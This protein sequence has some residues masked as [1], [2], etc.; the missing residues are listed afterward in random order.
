M[1]KLVTLEKVGYVFKKWFTLEKLVRFN[2]IDHIW[3]NVCSRLKN[4]SNFGKAFGEMGHTC[5]NLL[6]LE[7]W[8]TLNKMGW[9]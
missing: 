2:K 7:T 5:K 6:R 1:K 8:V 3:R 9:K 4:W